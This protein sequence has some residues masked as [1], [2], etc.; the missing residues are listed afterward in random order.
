MNTRL[1]FHFG[2]Q[3]VKD[4]QNYKYGVDN[5]YMQQ[6]GMGFLELD[7]GENALGKIRVHTETG[8]IELDSI[9]MILGVN[10]GR[11]TYQGIHG[12]DISGY[13]HDKEYVTY[14]EAYKNYVALMTELNNKGWKQYFMEGMPRY[15]AN[16]NIKRLYSG[17]T[18]SDSSQIFNYEEW[19]KLWKKTGNYGVSVYKDGVIVFINMSDRSDTVSTEIDTSKYV[20]IEVSYRFNTL[21]YWARNS[22]EN[23]DDMSAE[24]FKKAFDE[25]ILDAYESRLSMEQDEKA[26]GYQI[27]EN[28]V[29]PDYWKY[30]K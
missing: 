6:V 24:E 12:L 9:E 22:V 16:D 17:S 10:F 3:G 25:Y 27:D 14:E 23:S 18:G 26:E 5:N 30:A 20:K 15:A 2:E 1:D 19:Y 29:D 7:W 21:R 13:L 8:D 28:Y 11:K 4:F